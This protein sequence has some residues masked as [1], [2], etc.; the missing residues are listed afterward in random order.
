MPYD[1]TLKAVYKH[2]PVNDIQFNKDIVYSISEDGIVTITVNDGTEFD[3]VK[4]PAYLI[5][6]IGKMLNLTQKKKTLVK[7]EI[8][9]KEEDN[10]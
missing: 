1:P 8:K 3:E 6:E 7:R 10:G 5:F 9:N 2:S 4:V